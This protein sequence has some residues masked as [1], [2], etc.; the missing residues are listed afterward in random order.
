MEKGS[1]RNSC[2]CK[3]AFLREVAHA[4]IRLGLQN[5][6]ETLFSNV[7]TSGN[8]TI[9]TPPV[10]LHSKMGCFLQVTLTVAQHCMEGLE[11]GKFH[12]SLIRSAKRQKGRL[13]QDISPNFV[14]DCRSV[15]R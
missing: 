1:G 11:V 5:I 2:P 8:K 14:A 13:G 4:T 10:P 12:V 9:H 15:L 6:F 7:A 3:T